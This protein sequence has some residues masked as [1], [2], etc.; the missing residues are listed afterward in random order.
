MEKFKTYRVL[1]EGANYVVASRTEK[2]A[3]E[4]VKTYILQE[5]QELEESEEKW[6]VKEDSS[7]IKIIYDEYDEDGKQI[8]ISAIELLKSSVK[9]EILGCSDW[10]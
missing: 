2:E 3:I 1:A 8:I 4:T 7:D 10:Y 5:N 6:S 9:P